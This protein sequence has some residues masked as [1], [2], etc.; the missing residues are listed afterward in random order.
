M[1]FRRGPQRARY[2][3]AAAWLLVGGSS[4]TGCA[5]LGGLSGGDSDAGCAK[6]TSCADGEATGPRDGSSMDA[7]SHDA[8]TADGHASTDGNM[9]LRDSAP[10]D[11]GLGDAANAIVAVLPS[12][13]AF[14]DAGGTAGLVPCGTTPSPR[15]FTV[16]NHGMADFT[17]WTAFASGASS[18][19]SLSVDCTEA[20][21]CAVLAGQTATVTVTAPAVPANAG[22]ASYDDTLAIFTSAPGDLGHAVQL[23]LA[24]YG[25]IL[26]LSPSDEDFGVQ[27]N[28]GTYSQAV[29]VL[30][31]GNAPLMGAALA[32]A[33]G[34][35]PTLSVT[36]S[37]IDVPAATSTSVGST[38]V[39]A[40][41]APAG[42]TSAATA[43]VTILV[44][45]NSTCAPLPNGLTLEGRG[46]ASAVSVTSLLNFNAGQNGGVG[47]S[48]GTTGPMLDAVVTNIGSSIV[49][50]TG[51][52][53]GRG[54]S[55]PFTVSTTGL[56][57]TVGPSASVSLPVVPGAIAASSPPAASFNDTLTITTDA[58]GDTPHA[59]ALDET[60]AGATVSIIPSNITFSSTPLNQRAAYPLLVTNS[61]NIAA[62][63]T[64]SASNS[65]FTFDGNIVATPASS[66]SP[67]AYFTPTAVQTYATSGSLVVASGVP[68]CGAFDGTTDFM[69]SGAGSTSNAYSVAPGN[70]GFGANTCGAQGAAGTPPAAQ[71]VTISNF[72]A[73]SAKWTAILGGANPS[74]FMLSATSGSVPADM[75]STAG[76][77]SFSIAPIAL[78]STSGL[79][80]GEVADGITA[81]VSVIVGT[82][83][84]EET[85]TFPI[86]ETP[87]GA[88]PTWPQPA[89]LDVQGSPATFALDNACPTPA[90]FTFTSSSPAIFVV[91][92]SMGQA[93]AN[94]PLEAFV[95]ASAPSGAMATISASLA[96]PT[97]PLCG[98]LPSAIDVYVATLSSAASASASG[99]GS[100]SGS[101]DS[102][103]DAVP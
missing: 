48:C 37:T 4:L 64:L 74:Y 103:P 17:Y 22:L 13:V 88:F 65:V 70:I 66:V 57:I 90:T 31:S 6:G 80:A 68:L 51:L 101:H 97:T 42:T 75:S 56:P 100:G 87:T 50:I 33:P 96:S 7:K 16:A 14:G 95:N 77:S 15:T 12:L 41:F 98:P 21:P 8:T 94:A 91:S 27:P 38:T 84:T 93:S 76:T 83:P 52:S 89:I 73:S 59:V 29:Q 44:P 30:N 47:V 32:I 24:S 81:V 85:F 28:T 79:T 9:H 43:A 69:V 71:T 55:S 19:Y 78:S 40:N 39:T 36:P 61:G 82:A 72:T 92:P 25:A 2:L 3:A 53:L 60:S 18:R 102:G 23:V 11:T 5:S 45:A 1:A 54:T 63:V 20:T 46:S 34:S 35:S 10:L 58:L 99:S 49:H 67:N 62:P 26:Q 86:S